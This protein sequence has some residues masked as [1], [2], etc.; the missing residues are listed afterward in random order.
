MKSHLESK[1]HKDHFKFLA[2]K[3]SSPTAAFLQ[4]KLICKVCTIQLILQ[5]FEPILFTM[6]EQDIPD[7]PVHW[8][9]KLVVKPGMDIGMEHF[10]RKV[11]AAHCAACDLFIPM[12]LGLIQKHLKSHEHN[13]NR[14]GMMEQ[15]KRASMSVA[16]SIL[17][18]KVI[19]KK[20]DQYLK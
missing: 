6:S 2:T 9:I 11:E 13:L 15:S 17:N 18:H 20:L 14:K 5:Q 1:F 19:C 8:L 3:L 10:V 4:L 12:Q 16:R 7:L